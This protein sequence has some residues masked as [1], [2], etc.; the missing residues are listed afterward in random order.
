MW[1]ADPASDS[2]VLHPHRLY[3]LASLSLF[4]KK[5]F[6]EMGVCILGFRGGVGEEASWVTSMGVGSKGQSN[7]QLT[8]VTELGDW[9]GRDGCRPR[10]AEGLAPAEGT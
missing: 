7:S 5:S 3:G 2:L 10:S 9:S 6:T 4:Q 8:A 1:P